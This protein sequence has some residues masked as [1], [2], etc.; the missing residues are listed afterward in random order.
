MSFRS[1]ERQ[2]PSSGVTGREGVRSRGDGRR[3]GAKVERQ[4]N[5]VC[6]ADGRESR[7]KRPERAKSQGAKET[8]AQQQNAYRP[9]RSRLRGY[10]GSGSGT[11]PAG[12]EIAAGERA[13]EAGARP[14]DQRAI[15]GQAGT[16]AQRP[17]R[18]PLTL[19][20][21]FNQP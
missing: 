11:D 14:A 9:F 4:N 19:S 6:A 3:G 7:C 17:Q 18:G 8:L 20:T 2:T 12:G 13:G 10:P 15:Q 1:T 16:G 21:N 5:G